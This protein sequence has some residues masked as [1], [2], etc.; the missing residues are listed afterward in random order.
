MKTIQKINALNDKL[1]PFDYGMF[2]FRT[3]VSVQLVVVHGLKKIGIGTGIAEAVP[4]PFNLPVE[5]NKMF[6]ITANLI[7]PLF[8]IIGWYTRLATIPILSVTLIG[9]FVVHWGDP[10]LMSDIPFMYSLSFLFIACCGAGKFS[11]DKIVRPN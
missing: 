2:F 3:F 9:Y 7:F 8:V 5:F 1:V 10:L 4:N 6:A 11:I